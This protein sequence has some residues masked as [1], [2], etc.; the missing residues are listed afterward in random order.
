MSRDGGEERRKAERVAVNREFETLDPSFTYVSDLSETGVFIHTVERHPVGTRVQ[1]RFTI[2]LDDPVVID[3]TGLVV[4]HQDS[5]SG[6]GIRFDELDPATVLRLNDVVTRQ[7]PR[8]PGVPLD[9]EPFGTA[10]DDE[11][12]T[13]N[14]GTLGDDDAKTSEYRPGTE[15]D[16]A[17]RTG[18]EPESGGD[19]DDDETREVE[20]ATQELGMGPGFDDGSA[21]PATGREDGPGE[22]EDGGGGGGGAPKG[23]PS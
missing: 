1:L 19:S 5:P 16:D 11:E 18:L 6:M 2:L 15:E 10:D 23:A 12:L 8:D 22:D 13:R 14:L 20:L 4:R 17:T 7:R 3:G 21:E 9:A